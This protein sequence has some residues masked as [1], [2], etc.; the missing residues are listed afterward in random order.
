MLQLMMDKIYKSIKFTACSKDI[1]HLRVDVERTKS[2]YNKIA[3]MLS[4]IRQKLVVLRNDKV[5]LEEQLTALH[6]LHQKNEKQ[7]ISINNHICSLC[8][9]QL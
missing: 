9:S 8:K 1:E 2:E 3:R 6:L 4:D 5:D 7:I